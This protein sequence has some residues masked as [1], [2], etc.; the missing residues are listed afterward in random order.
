MI[1]LL[2]MT[3]KEGIKIPDRKIYDH[4]SLQFAVVYKSYVETYKK[5]Q[6]LD[7][8]ILKC[9]HK[10]FCTHRQTGIIAFPLF[11]E[12]KSGLLRKDT[13]G[14]IPLYHCNGVAGGINLSMPEKIA[15]LLPKNGKRENILFVQ[16]P[17]WADDTMLRILPKQEY[18]FSFL[19]GLLKNQADLS[20]DT[21]SDDQ[22]V[23]PMGSLNYLEIP[24]FPEKLRIQFQKEMKP[25][26]SEIDTLRK[27]QR[28][29]TTIFYD[30]CDQFFSQN[31]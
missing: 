9:F 21:N 31:A 16:Y 12:Q 7:R 13:H 3:N 10:Q 18:D 20:L 27:K 8:F 29:L 22:A 26:F 5:E 15:I 30:L 6:I 25:F 17:F 23:L 11:A 24:L 19:Y 28:M 2:K 14:V 4:V 1:D